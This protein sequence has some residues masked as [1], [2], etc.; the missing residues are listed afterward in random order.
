VE[1]KR[2]ASVASR[3]FDRLPRFG[4]LSLLL[5]S[6]TA[7]N[8]E[9]QSTDPRLR[10]VDRTIVKLLGAKLREQ[11]PTPATK[12]SKDLRRLIVELE[13]RQRELDQRCRP[14]QKPS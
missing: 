6:E 5:I 4:R 3:I 11:L 12:S 9:L 8:P 1:P 7:I 13:R 14:Q 2:L 10:H